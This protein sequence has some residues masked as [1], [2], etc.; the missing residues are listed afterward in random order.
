MR[1]VFGLHRESQKFPELGTFD[2]RKKKKASFE[3]EGGR[4]F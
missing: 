3:K 4:M 1:R 2:L